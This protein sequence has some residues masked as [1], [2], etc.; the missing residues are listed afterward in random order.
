MKY[1][2]DKL[3][4]I[5]LKEARTRHKKSKSHTVESIK[6]GFLRGVAVIV[7]FER[8]HKRF[9]RV[10]GRDLF[11]FDSASADPYK[12]RRFRN[13]IKLAELVSDWSWSLHVADELATIRVE[14]EKLRDPSNL[15]TIKEVE[16]AT[17]VARQGKTGRAQNCLKRIGKQIYPI[18]QSI[19]VQVVT[20]Y[21]EQQLMGPH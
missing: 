14:L 15:K 18:A 16:K 20:R 19:G 6:D 5:A 12:P 11:Y 21:L 1:D 9:N 10:I 2:I 8:P 3:Q 7:S 4:E 17:A 13:M